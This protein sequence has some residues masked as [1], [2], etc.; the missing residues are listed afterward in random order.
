MTNPLRGIREEDIVKY[1]KAHNLSVGKTYVLTMKYNPW[2]KDLL[3][4][5]VFNTLWYAME[6]TA[7][8]IVAATNNEFIIVNPNAILGSGNLAKLDDK[9]LRRIPWNQLTNFE[10]INKPTTQIIRFT[11]NSKTEEWSVPTESAS[12]WHF[13]VYNLDNLRKTIQ[14]HIS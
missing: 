4:L 7:T 9:H 6:G 14:S 12:V 2:W 1:F 3:K 13:N 5:F 8:R 11:V 10:V